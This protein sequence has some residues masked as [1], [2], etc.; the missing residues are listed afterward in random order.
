M[1]QEWSFQSNQE[2]QKKKPAIVRYAEAE[3]GLSSADQDLTIGDNLNNALK[4]EMGSFLSKGNFSE[5]QEYIKNS[6]AGIADFPDELKMKMIIK[7]NIP[8]QIGLRRFLED[9]PPMQS[10]EYPSANQIADKKIAGLNFLIDL[11]KNYAVNKKN[12]NLGFDPEKI[13][14]PDF[15]PYSTLL[16]LGS[17]MVTLYLA[18][19][20]EKT[21][22]KAKIT[23]LIDAYL[24]LIEEENDDARFLDTG[25]FVHYT[26]ADVRFLN[27]PSS[28]GKLFR[29]KKAYVA[30][31]V[32]S[33]LSQKNHSEKHRQSLVILLSDT[34]GTEEVRGRLSELIY[35]ENDKGDQKDQNI[36]NNLEYARA[37]ITPNHEKIS[38]E[39]MNVLYGDKIKFED[40]GL[41]EK[42]TP[43]EVPLLKSLIPKD[44]KVLDMGCGPGRLLLV[45]QEDGYDITGYDFTD[46]HVRYIK[47]KSPE[48][49]VLKGDWRN[50]ALKDGSFDIAY[51]LGRNILHEYSLPD[52]VQTF[53]EAQRVLGPQG[54]FIFDIPDRDKGQYR[55]R[56]LDYAETMHD[57][58]VHNFRYGAIYD[59]PDEKHFSTRYAYSNEDIENLA[60]LAGFRIIEVRRE[61]LPTSKGD[62]NLYYVLKKRTK[63]KDMQ[64]NWH[65][66][67]EYEEKALE[68]AQEVAAEGGTFEEFLGKMPKD[69]SLS[70]GGQAQ[71]IW[72]AAKDPLRME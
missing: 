27:K 72:W 71:E 57:F 68:T 4:D 26:D 56:V 45:L 40:Y 7:L 21:R 5:F 31:R 59:S 43:K 51:S 25:S 14:P 15:N 53:R 19:F 20:P 67:L 13:K 42:M 16:E 18:E 38:T 11:I 52:Q 37:L 54:Q 61:K 48:A 49:K 17:K 44:K 63:I 34:I 28:L 30:E 41:N 69:I 58:G 39:R 8:L 33:S 10:S 46:R 65:T 24:N 2:A 64:G 9:I 12:S 35:K 6:E 55:R 70:G 60:Q 32:L 47:K 62:E 36:I 66:L 22:D 23:D 1:A 3:K 50:T 29:E